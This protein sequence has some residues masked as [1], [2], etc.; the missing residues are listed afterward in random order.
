MERTFCQRCPIIPYLY[1][2]V[3][4]L[5]GYMI[6]NPRYKIEKLTLLDGT[7]IQNQVFADDTMMFLKGNP[8]NLQK[9][10]QVLQTF[11]EASRGKVNWHKPSAIWASKKKR[12]WSWGENKGLFW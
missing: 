11:C 5:L 2:F 3:V 6:S 9:T 4:Y 12:K 10:F 8:N 7:Q 1:L